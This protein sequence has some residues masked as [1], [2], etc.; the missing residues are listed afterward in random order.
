M[1]QEMGNQE[2]EA[3]KLEY[4]MAQEMLRHYDALNWQIGSILIAAVVILSGFAINKD[5]IELAKR[6]PGVR[7]MLI[8]SLPSLSLFVLGVWLLWFRRHRFLYNLRNEV[9][10]RLESQLGMYHHLRVAESV[11]P[12]KNGGW[13]NRFTNAKNEAGHDD[14]HFRPFYPLKP[15]GPSGYS[16]AKILVFGLPAAQLLL[17]LLIFWFLGLISPRTWFG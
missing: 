10:H 4:Q 11:P 13:H 14:D 6:G 3:K 16:L 5:V 9:L 17:L 12:K 1:R 15:Q 2:F 7:W 8:L